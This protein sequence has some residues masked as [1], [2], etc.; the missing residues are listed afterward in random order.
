MKISRACDDIQS[1]VRTMAKYEA[2]FVD[3]MMQQELG[4]N[5][6][7]ETEADLLKEGIFRVVAS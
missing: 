1:V 2:L 3:V 4:L 7:D 6:P 5:P